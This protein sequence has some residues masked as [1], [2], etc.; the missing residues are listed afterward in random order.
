MHVFSLLN[1]P[2]WLVL[3]LLTAVLGLACGVA[4]LVRRSAALRNSVLLPTLLLTFV[5]PF[6]PW[7]APHLPFSI[8]VPILGEESASPPVSFSNDAAG[9]E[10]RGRDAASSYNFR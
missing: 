5:V 8:D 7:V 1:Q 3:V 10:E 9:A 6:V 2:F 4:F